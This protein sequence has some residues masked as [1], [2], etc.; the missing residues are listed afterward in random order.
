MKQLIL[1]VLT[2]ALV[3]CASTEKIVVKEVK[4]PVPV[5]C[6]IEAPEKPH[7]P[8]T[9]EDLTGDEYKDTQRA[10]A[11]IEIRKGYEIKLEGAITACNKLGLQ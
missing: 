5:Y 2:A 9:D 4:V 1:L 3:G 6:N 8:Y 10:L 7:F 11:E